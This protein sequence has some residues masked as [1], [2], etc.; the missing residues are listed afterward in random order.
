VHSEDRATQKHVLAP[1]KLLV[2]TRPH[3]E[4]GAN[5]TVEFRPAQGWLSD[6]GEDLEQRRFARS[7]APD[8]AHDGSAR[9]V[10]GDVAKGP[11]LF[12][13]S[14]PALAPEGARQRG[15]EDL[16]QAA[17]GISLNPNSVPL[18]QACCSDGNVGHQITSAKVCSVRRK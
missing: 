16:G 12:A 7:V 8:N 18:G 3:L 1:G 6:P 14:R 5:T 17:V 2:K 9:N 15:P 11:E 10:E 4:Q 13:T